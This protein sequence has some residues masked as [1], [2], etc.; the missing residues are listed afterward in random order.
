MVA[1]HNTSGYQRI[2]Q[3]VLILDTATVQ[4]QLIQAN[5]TE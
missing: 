2:S 1:L 3:D 4:T 5:V